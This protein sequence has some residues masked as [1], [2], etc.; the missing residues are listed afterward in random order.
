[1]A[2]FYLLGHTTD[3]Q[4]FGAVIQTK[5]KTIVFDGGTTGDYEQLADFLRSNAASHVD[6]WF[7]THPHHDHIGS[8]HAISKYAPD[9]TVD[10]IYHCFPTLEQLKKA[11]V[12]SEIEEKMWIAASEW[13]QKYNVHQLSRDDHFYFD[14]VII[15]VLRIFNPDISRNYVNNSS[16]VYRIEGPQK[17]ILI[18]GDLGAEGGNELMNICSIELLRADYTQM[19]HHGQ[20][21]VSREFYAHIRAKGCL[22]ASPQWLWDN[23]AGNGFDTGP[24]KTVRTRELVAELGA[25][26]HIIEKDGTQK[27]EI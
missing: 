2:L 24:W 6:A 8:F 7:F 10:V 26:E 22:W 18:L 15:R 19:A 12:R 14:D 25:T 23:D 4:M 16:T 3:S 5:T 17:S 9:I 11:G 1:M 20:N 21:G 27:I 13:G